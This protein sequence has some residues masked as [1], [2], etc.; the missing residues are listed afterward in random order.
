MQKHAEQTVERQPLLDGNNDTEDDSAL[1]GAG[2]AAT[3]VR[4]SPICCLRNSAAV[5][6]DAYIDADIFV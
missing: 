6:L 5:P 1:P 2:G 4:L 3:S